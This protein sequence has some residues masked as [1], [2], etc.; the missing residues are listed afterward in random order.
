MYPTYDANKIS[1]I[2]TPYALADSYKGYGECA[3]K[4]QNRTSWSPSTSP[5]V[6]SVDYIYPQNVYE[7][8]YVP[9][10]DVRNYPLVLERYDG[11][12]PIGVA[13]EH[14][15]PHM[16]ADN[17]SCGMYACAPGVIPRYET[18]PVS[19]GFIRDDNVCMNSSGCVRNDMIE[20]AL[21]IMASIMAV[22]VI[23]MWFRKDE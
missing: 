1:S 17:T 14:A 12:I 11:E 19:E 4:L 21:I 6:I 22:T 3:R 16:T 23:A 5:D 13:I 7:S 20:K 9:S 2:G 10:P 8:P 18:I 15:V